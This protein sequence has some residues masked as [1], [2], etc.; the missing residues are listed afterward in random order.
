MHYALTSTEP[1]KEQVDCFIVGI[2]QNKK[3]SKAAEQLDKAS[4]GA[5]R[6][7][8]AKGDLVEE[9]GKNL[10][11]YSIPKVSSARILLVYC[12][13]EASLKLSDFRKISTCVATV[14]KSMKWNRVVNY[15][16][17]L[18]IKDLSA[19]TKVRQSIELLED[20]FYSFNQFKTKKSDKPAFSLPKDFVFSVAVEDASNAEK[21]IKHAVA[22]TSGIKLTKDL[23]NLPANVCTPRYMAEQAKVLAK[24]CKLNIQILKKDAIAKEGMGALLAVAQGSNEPPYFVVLEYKGAKKG[25]KPVVLV[26]KGVTF[27]SGG[28]CIKP[29]PG[30]EEMKFDMAGAASVLGILKAIALLKL[31]INVFGI[32]PLTENLPSGSAVK[33]GDIVTS[34]SGQTIEVINTDAEGRLILADAL[35]YSERYEPDVVIDM[36][37]LTGAMVVALGSVATGLM[38]NDRTLSNELETASE[39]SHDRVW[40]LPLWDDYQEQ[41]DSYFADISNTGIGG[42][43]SI[44]AACFLSR[45]TKKFRWAHLD[46]AGTAWRSDKDKSAT[47]RPVSLLVQ[48]LL[49]RS[50]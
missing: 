37:T 26:G 38:S 22:I 15:L 39:Q 32:I 48:F 4:G 3:L 2:F 42:G 36:A 20:C 34:L 45:F 33:P 8:L 11:I 28:I 23:A 30:M 41:I 43:K 17:D 49:N 10:L 9:L 44:T 12:G 18:E 25:Q 29:G 7:L 6:S 5:I 46:I 24:E 27:D 35:T 40:P 50:D 31:P 13:K 16:T 14:V 47:G 21:A 1:V 19:Y